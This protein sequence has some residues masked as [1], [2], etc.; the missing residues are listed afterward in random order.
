VTYRHT[1]I[2]NDAWPIA[3]EWLE[4]AETLGG[5]LGSDQPPS[6]VPSA[7]GWPDQDFLPEEQQQESHRPSLAEQ[8]QRRQKTTSE[9]TESSISQT[10]LEIG[11]S[12]LEPSFQLPGGTSVLSGLYLPISSVADPAN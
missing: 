1:Y 2:R 7:S 8:Q 5:P 12:P 11:P 3:V 10:M 6:P 9:C 4:S